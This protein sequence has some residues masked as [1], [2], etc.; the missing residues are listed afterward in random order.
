[1]INA[2]NGDIEFTR[3]PLEALVFYRFD[4]AR[5]G[6]GVTYHLNPE[7]EGSGVVSPLNVKFDDA[8]GFVLQADFLVT[9]K[10]AIGLRYTSLNYEVEGVAAKAKSDGLGFT[11]SY[12]F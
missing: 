12:R 5:L 6:G 10:M 4:R 7:L 2:S 8:L 1:M 11:F 3:L 9:D